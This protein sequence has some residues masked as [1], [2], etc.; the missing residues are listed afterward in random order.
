MKETELN[1]KIEKNYYIIPSNTFQL[2]KEN[3]DLLAYAYILNNIT[4]NKQLRRKETISAFKVGKEINLSND[5]TKKSIKRLS[6]AGLLAYAY[7][8]KGVLYISNVYVLENNKG[9]KEFTVLEQIKDLWY[10]VHLGNIKGYCKIPKEILLSNEMSYKQKVLWIKLYHG[11]TTLREPTLS[12]IATITNSDYTQFKKDT[13]T[14]IATDKTPNYIQNYKSIANHGVKFTM[15]LEKKLS[16]DNPSFGAYQANDDY[17]SNKLSA[18]EELNEMIN[19][20][21]EETEDLLLKMFSDAEDN[22]YEITEEIANSVSFEE[23]AS[24]IIEEMINSVSFEE[25]I[26]NLIG[27][28]NMRKVFDKNGKFIEAAFDLEDLKEKNKEKADLKQKILE[29][30]NEVE[31]LKAELKTAQQT[32]AFMAENEV[33]DTAVENACKEL[34][35]NKKI[36]TDADIDRWS[37]YDSQISDK[38]DFENRKEINKEESSEHCSMIDQAEE[39]KYLYH[40]GKIAAFRS[41]IMHGIDDNDK[42]A[43]AF[44]NAHKGEWE[45]EAEKSQAL[46]QAK[47]LEQERAENEKV[48]KMKKIEKEENTHVNDNIEEYDLDALALCI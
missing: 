15:S 24:E 47:L 40:Q 1:L 36:I 39:D 7:N 48:L 16:K 46:K 20:S 4:I 8:K 13:K 9:N 26:N 43:I 41:E 21:N 38:R 30:Q 44:Y 3:T 19:K 2:I 10:M 45:D 18:E 25:Q 33:K 22:T 11:M 23:Q 31:E 35:T 37:N 32:K 14:L 27:G 17:A 12:G 28:D 34:K 5:T 29:L 42:K 6:E